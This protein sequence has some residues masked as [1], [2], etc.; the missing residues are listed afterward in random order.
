M[1][2][3]RAHVQAHPAHAYAQFSLQHLVVALALASI[4]PGLARLIFPEGSTGEGSNGADLDA[5]LTIPTPFLHGLAR[6]YQRRIGEHCGPPNPRPGFWCYQQAALTYPAQ[7]R[8]MSG[9]LVREDSADPL[10]V[11]PFGGRNRESPVALLLKD[12]AES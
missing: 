5:L 6:S 4:V 9:Q 11:Y 10:V 7:F 2:A 12:A 8:Q 1:A 3:V